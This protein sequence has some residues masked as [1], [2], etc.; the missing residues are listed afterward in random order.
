MTKLFVFSLLAGLAYLAGLS[1]FGEVGGWIALA[2]AIY[3]LT[4]QHIRSGTL[5]LARVLLPLVICWGVMRWFSAD[6]ENITTA[7]RIAGWTAILGG[8]AAF[9]LLYRRVKNP[10]W[11]ALGLAAAMFIIS[12]SP[13]LITVVGMVFSV[14]AL[15]KGA[16]IFLAFIG[17]ERNI[18][19]EILNTLTIGRGVNDNTNNTRD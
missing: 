15:I 4:P 12:W 14:W 17:G 13:L 3:Y 6:P 18:E 8:F 1:F 9:A 11:L 7:S 5:R 2:A 10:L 19:A 16:S